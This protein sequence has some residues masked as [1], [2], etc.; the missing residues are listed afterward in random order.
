MQVF[1]PP[2]FRSA[3]Q[4]WVANPDYQRLPQSIAILI[5]ANDGFGLSN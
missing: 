4:L 3:D 1:G 2:C 5:S